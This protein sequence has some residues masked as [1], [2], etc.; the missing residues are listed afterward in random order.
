MVY[1]MG[2]TLV[3]Q[4]IKKIYQERKEILKRL[5]T[6]YNKIIAS[7]P[8]VS[9]KKKDEIKTEEVS[10][11]WNT[12]CQASIDSLTISIVRW[13]LVDCSVDVAKWQ[14]TCKGDPI[15]IDILNSVENIGNGLQSE[16]G[17]LRKKF[18]LLD[19][20]FNCLL[21]STESQEGKAIALN[22]NF[23]KDHYSRQ[24]RE[25]SMLAQRIIL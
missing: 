11:I 25:V 22:V 19:L 3:H 18:P 21:S 15:T 14:D 1:T 12:L 7:I 4:E 10:K 6:F 8:E 5:P 2:S 23:I 24:I 9:R 20:V 13:L 17:L 16:I